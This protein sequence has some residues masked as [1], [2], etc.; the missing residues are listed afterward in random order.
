MALITCPECSNKISDRA[1]ICPHCGF[2]MREGTILTPKAKRGRKRRPNG[3]G[4]IVKLSGRRA[5]PYQVRVNTHLDERGYPAFDVLGSYPDMAVAETALAEYRKNPYDVEARKLTF[6]QLYEL[7][8]RDKYEISVKKLSRSSRDCTRSAYAHCGEL[9]DK[10]YC[11][12]KKEDFQAVL[13]SSDKGGKSL[14]HSMQEHIRNLFRQMDQYALQNDIIEKGYSAFVK[15]TVEEDDESG[16]PFTDEELRKLWKHKDEPFVDTILIYCYSGWRINELAR[17]PLSSIDLQERTFT[18]GLKNRY[19]RNRT[20]PIHS[21]IYDMVSRRYDLHH[22]SLIYHDGQKN[23]S[24]PKYR[25]YFRTALSA[26]GIESE[27]TPHDCRHTFNKLLTDAGA[28]RICR[29][30]LMGHA[31]ADINENVY[32]HKTVEQLREA[33]EMIKVRP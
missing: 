13:L 18:G 25:E 9:Y 23:I 11:R 7:Y 16:I 28:D 3:S 6:T 21:A 12:L 15:I 24:E 1:P 27:H 20:V 29:Y 8:Y 5:R 19:S 30:R 26:C 22:K 2:P 31:G 17:M 14:S 4:T 32:S 33:I 10:T